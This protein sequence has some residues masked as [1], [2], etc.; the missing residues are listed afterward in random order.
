VLPIGFVWSAGEPTR[1]GTAV[2]LVAVLAV[3]FLF[4]RVHQLWTYR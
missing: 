3:A 2:L 1:S 4:L